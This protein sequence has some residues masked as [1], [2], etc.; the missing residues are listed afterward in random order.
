MSTAGEKFAAAVRAARK[1]RK[2]SQQALAEAIEGS[3]DGV[4]AVERNVNDASLETAA[5]LIQAL[6]LDANKVFGGAARDL[7][8]KRLDLEAKLQRLVEGVD[9]RGMQ[10]FVE[11][12]E[13]IAKIH[14]ADTAKRSAEDDD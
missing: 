5:A 1:E 12:A 13:A 8:T 6:N 9:D 11:I 10:L 14:P 4:S 3:V 7:S 2:L